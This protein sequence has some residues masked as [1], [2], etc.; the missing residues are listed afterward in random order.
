MLW[1]GAFICEAVVPKVMN[2]LN[3]GGDF[4]TRFTFFNRYAIG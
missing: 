2:V 4:L 3:K 1:R